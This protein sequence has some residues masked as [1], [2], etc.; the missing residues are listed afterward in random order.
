MAAGA[1][2]PV[3]CSVRNLQWGEKLAGGY[4]PATGG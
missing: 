4:V 2:L 3:A 1:G